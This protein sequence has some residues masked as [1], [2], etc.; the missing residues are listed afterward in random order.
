[1][2][3]RAML[4]L[5]SAVYF[6]APNVWADDAHAAHHP[7][8][9]VQT[10]GASATK[11]ASVAQSGSTPGSARHS[12]EARDLM[13]KMMTQMDRIRETKDPVERKRLLDEHMQTMQDAMRAMHPVGGPMMMDMMGGQGMGGVASRTES[14][15][16][17]TAPK[18][19]M[20][21]MEERMDMMQM[22]MEQML[23]QQKQTA[24]AQ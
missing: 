20:N 11:P 3:T 16:R 19:R 5:A 14:G 7:E 2:K 17:N 24:P 12:D 15:Q 21:M 4:L 10:T 22:M 9:T 8:S 18:Q 6:A 13:Q 1:M 23:E